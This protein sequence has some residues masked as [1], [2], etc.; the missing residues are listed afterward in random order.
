MPEYVRD[1]IA[2]E[3]KR[4]RQEVAGGMLMGHPVELDNA[5][6]LLVTAYWMGY[7]EYWHR[8]KAVAAAIA[9]TEEV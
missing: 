8:D 5:D 9:A 6:M 2:R 1:W 7:G 4:I 3:A